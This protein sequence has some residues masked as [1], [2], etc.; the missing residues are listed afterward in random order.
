MFLSHLYFATA[1]S[2]LAMVQTLSISSAMRSICLEE[3][4][5]VFLKALPIANLISYKV[6]PFLS[7]K[8]CLLNKSGNFFSRTIP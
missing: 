4:Q 6:L 7:F 5:G 1:S 2:Q 8:L 3:T